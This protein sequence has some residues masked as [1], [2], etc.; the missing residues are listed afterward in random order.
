MKCHV[1]SPF[2][3]VCF[4][5]ALRDM[6]GG[7]ST[8]VQDMVEQCGETDEDELGPASRP[9]M[10][11]IIGNGKS[12]DN[13]GLPDSMR[14]ESV[15][16]VYMEQNYQDHDLH[17][18]LDWEILSC[19]NTRSG[20]RFNPDIGWIAISGPSNND[21]TK[22]TQSW[23]SLLHWTLIVPCKRVHL[24]DR[25]PDNDPDSD[26]DP[27]S[28]NFAPCKRGICPPPLSTREQYLSYRTPVMSPLPDSMRD[29]YV[30]C[31]WLC[32]W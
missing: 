10:V 9:S 26:L 13:I 22:W 5:A 1:M 6:P 4:Q 7:V 31:Y 20:S 8:E 30:S 18:D 25:D 2:C 12:L 32:P 27:V 28:E 14:G 24:L 3:P 15:Y 21:L 29:E 11:C 23:R 17:R 19:V 16:P